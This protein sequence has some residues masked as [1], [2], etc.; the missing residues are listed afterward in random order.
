MLAEQNAG[1][2]NI[3]MGP[4]EDRTK[5]KKS[6]HAIRREGEDDGISHNASQLHG[7]I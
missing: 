1:R 3:M 4:E 6:L 2:V 7:F 5:S